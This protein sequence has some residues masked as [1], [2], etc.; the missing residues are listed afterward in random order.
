MGAHEDVRTW[1]D[2]TGACAGDHMG[3]VCLSVYLTV[4][5][6]ASLSVWLF[7][8]SMSSSCLKCMCAFVRW[9]GRSVMHSFMHA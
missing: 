5:L 6:L 7:T 1:G 9:F 3:L 8:I 2:S 4:C